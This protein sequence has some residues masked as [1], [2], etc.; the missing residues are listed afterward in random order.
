M[1]VI[2]IDTETALFRPGVMAPELA[3]ATWASKGSSGIVHHTEA[4]DWLEEILRNTEIHIVG[5]FF[6]YDAAVFC[7][8]FPDLVPLVF[9]AY[10]ADRITCSK[11]R[12][13]LVDI[14]QGTYRGRAASDGTWIKYGYSLLEVAKR[15][16]G[17]LL[18]KDEW[19]LKYG[20]L[21]P[22]PLSQWPEGAVK[23]A[24]DDAIATLACYEAQESAP[25]EWLVDQYR[26]TR[27]DFAL[28]LSS[29]WGLRTHKEG[30]DA[31]QAHVEA[32]LVDVTKRLVES[33]LV[34]GDG[35]RDTKKAAARMVDVC[36]RDGLV[37]RKTKGG[38]VCLDSDACDE[39]EDPLLVD[40]GKF[41]KLGKTLN[42]DIP[43]LSAGTVYPVHCRYGLAASSRATCSNPNI[44]NLSKK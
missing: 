14:A 17:R 4:H 24:T 26:Q 10:D 43:M 28:H 37:L 5:H 1:Q 23:Y 29:C 12:M 2:A 32:E 7:S 9:A 34:R 44:Q 42:A 41:S 36:Q 30:V 33:G 40:Y 8:A 13:Q 27:A 35:S 3:C 19:R 38:G 20:E 18:E 15:L 21:I 22:L 6:S 11:L 39:T 25:K 16:T 31:V